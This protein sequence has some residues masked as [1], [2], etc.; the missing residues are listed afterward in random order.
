MRELK[1]RAWDG[2]KFVLVEK[3]EFI[4]A[5][6]SV[7]GKNGYNI[8]DVLGIPEEYLQQYT[9]LKDKN[10]KEIYE[11]DIVENVNFI[12]VCEYSEG[13]FYLKEVISKIPMF[14]VDD[15]NTFSHRIMGAICW[16]MVIGNIFET[17]ELLAKK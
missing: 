3:L 17:P 8:N 10:G 1:F 14:C 12:G 5:N 6:K 13:G 16:D 4:P 9:G 11:G 15:L 2:K 7:T